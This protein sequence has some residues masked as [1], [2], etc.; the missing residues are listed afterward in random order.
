V[1]T[2][3]GVPNVVSDGVVTQHQVSPSNDAGAATLTVTGE[4]LL[5]LL[6]LEQRG[7]Q[8]PAMPYT[9][10]VAAI[11]LPYLRHGIVPLVVPPVTLD[12]ENPLERIPVQRD[13]DLGYLNQ[14][15]E[16]VGYTFFLLPGPAPLTSVAY[17]GPQVRV[18]VPQPALS[19]N[20]DAAS[21]VESLSFA[22]DGL[23]KSRLTVTVQ[24]PFTKLPIP[25]PL[26]DVSLLRPPLA[27]RPAPTLRTEDLA[28]VAKQH[29]VKAALLG[30]SRSA[31]GTDTIR[32]SGQ[33]DVLR[34]GRVLAPRQ[35]VGVRGAGPAY[36]GPYYVESVTHSIRPGSYRQSFSLSRD[37]F[38]SILPRVPV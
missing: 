28:G 13:T 29:P 34:Y 5:L 31:A 24:E 15:A 8:F 19:V 33:L 12:V 25:V 6:D 17:W 35:L 36:D 1:A 37:G 18:G 20:L 23:S 2:V 4:D 30:L 27:L 7:R 38:V 14:L 21:N 11:L 26:P 3:N 16:D 9:A 32:G 10:R 22:Y